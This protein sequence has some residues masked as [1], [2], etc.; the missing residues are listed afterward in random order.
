MT[1]FPEI[2]TETL[3]GWDGKLKEPP[4]KSVIKSRAPTVR[5]IIAAVSEQ[6]GFTP[7]QISGDGRAREVTQARH[8]AF[9]LAYLYAGKNLTHIGRLFNKHHTTILHGLKAYNNNTRY[10]P[11]ILEL[12]A[13]VEAQLGLADVFNGDKT[14][15]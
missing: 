13:K 3:H 7:Q 8:V 15:E 14:N 2:N 10:Y 12:V 11:H 5:K 6:S 1:P 4:W 9:H